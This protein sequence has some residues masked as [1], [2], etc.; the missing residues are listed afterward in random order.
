MALATILERLDRLIGISHLANDIL[1]QVAKFLGGLSFRS[2]A[3]GSHII[4]LPLLIILN[5]SC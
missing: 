5:A 3:L 2:G 4:H 1:K